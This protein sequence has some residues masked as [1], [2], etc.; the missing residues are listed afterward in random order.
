M[1]KVLTTILLMVLINSLLMG[2]VAV[3]KVIS[4]QPGT[5]IF[6][7]NR[8]LGMTNLEA[9]ENQFISDNIESG[10][11]NFSCSH[12]EKK[13]QTSFECAEG[14]TIKITADFGKK[15]IA[16]NINKE[17]TILTNPSAD[18][19]INGE[20]VG[21]GVVQIRL[22]EGTYTIQ[23]RKMNYKTISKI[24]TIDQNLNYTYELPP[25]AG[26]ISVSTQPEVNADLY[27]E[28]KSVGTTPFTKSGYKAGR[29]LIELQKERWIPMKRRIT[30][31]P[32]KGFT[33]TFEMMPITG[34][35]YV[36]AHCAQT[37][38]RNIPDL[39]VI[40]DNKYVGSSTNSE[41]ELQVG[42]HEITLNNPDYFCD[43]QI[44]SISE[45]KRKELIFSVESFSWYNSK[46][47]KV[48][49]NKWIGITSTILLA[50][51]GAYLNHISDRYYYDDYLNARTVSDHSKYEKKFQDFELYR[52]CTVGISI[53][54]VV[55]TYLS[56]RAEKKYQ[57]IVNK[58]KKQ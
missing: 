15:T 53:G 50:G 56:W 24:L 9:N 28:N 58:Y 3:L 36:A 32:E 18:I 2:S 6:L 4:D 10:H 21:H 19:Y 57:K 25:D 27:I 5:V 33:G 49:I 22:Y 51:G 48:K 52:D 37:G 45:N 35:L 39:R 1:N 44:I 46:I 17:R 26:I 54:A 29:Y 13:L 41:T 23:V 40:A 14:D 55:Y 16:V 20:L 38:E 7:D 31:L 8:E 34:N 43:P 30:V 11:H 12:G 47:S 42:E